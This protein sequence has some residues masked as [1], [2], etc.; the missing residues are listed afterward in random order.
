MK[1][2]IGFLL[3]GA[4]ATLSC[5]ELKKELPAPVAPGVNVH[6]EA[7]IDPANPGFHG[8]QLLAA[9]PAWN[10]QSCQVC[11]GGDFRGG[12]A[13]VA[14]FKCHDP[15]PH[16]VMF[17]KATGR[18]Q[19]YLRA[20]YYT[21]SACQACHGATYTGSPDV[22]VSCEQSGCHVDASGN[23]KSPETCNTCHGTFSAPANL[24]GLPLLLSAAPPNGVAGDTSA[25]SPAVGAHQKH[26]VS[27]ATGKTVKCQ[28]CHVVPN[29]WSDPGHI[30]RPTMIANK[31][32]PMFVSSA[33][34][35]QVATVLFNDTL[36]NLVTGNGSVVPHPAF[37][38]T[39]T[40]C[41][42]TYC[43]GNWML[44]KSSAPVAARGVYKD[45]ATVMFGTSASPAWTGGSA[46]G[47]CY[48]CHGL[49]PGKYTPAGHTDYALSA[50]S[51]CHGDVTDGNGNILNR[52][53]H[54]NGVIDLV[55]GFG[56][57]R[58]MH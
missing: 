46:E 23:P 14:C 8:K 31:N 3:A 39:T 19:G 18:H 9:V 15:Y 55:N 28:E 47:Q 49:A 21:L 34:G 37:D 25:S 54:M 29:S 17:P 48:S 32:T 36:A 16:S 10:D 11:H 52:A 5:S 7:W 42:N 2:Q 12:T 58:P 33:V 4:L 57:P 53:K 38:P 27:G 6:T 50:C 22:A 44:L 43:H 35:T 13:G 51:I 56:G 45:T 41:A 20:H 24:T 40:K 26:L 30:S 1:T